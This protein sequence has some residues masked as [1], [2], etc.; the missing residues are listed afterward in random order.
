MADI[1]DM[2]DVKTLWYSCVRLTLLLSEVV[3]AGITGIA[4]LK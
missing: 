1:T 3:L 2:A 4:E